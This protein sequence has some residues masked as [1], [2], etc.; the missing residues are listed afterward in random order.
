MYLPSCSI[1]SVRSK[2][3]RSISNFISKVYSITFSK[4]FRLFFK[5]NEEIANF[6]EVVKLILEKKLLF[7]EFYLYLFH[8]KWLCVTNFCLFIN[9]RFRKF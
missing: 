8:K 5:F 1:G 3:L 2:I 7:H 6:D 4:I 9:Q